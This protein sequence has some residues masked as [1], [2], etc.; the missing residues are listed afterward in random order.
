MVNSVNLFPENASKLIAFTL[1]GI[2]TFVRELFSNNPS[3]M[4]N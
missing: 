2:T 1:E 3:G 4:I